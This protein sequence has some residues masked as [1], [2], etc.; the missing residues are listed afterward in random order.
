MSLF[1][2]AVAVWIGSVLALLQDTFLGCSEL[3]LWAVRGAGENEDQIK[4][5]VQVMELLG[6]VPSD[7]QGK[8]MQ[9]GK[10]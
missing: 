1:H 4:M 2:T 8:V 3:Q 7:I 5:F 9:K 10:M 6:F